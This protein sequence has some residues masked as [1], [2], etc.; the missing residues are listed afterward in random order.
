MVV[1]CGLRVDGDDVVD[2]EDGNC[3]MTIPKANTNNAIHFL[4]D[5]DLFKRSTDMIAVVRIF[6]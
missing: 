6:D 5:N 2:E 3:V 1:M 4:M